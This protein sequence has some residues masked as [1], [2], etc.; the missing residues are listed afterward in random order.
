MAALGAEPRIRR[1]G[2][3]TVR[4]L[5]GL[6]GLNCRAIME[7]CQMMHQARYHQADSKP[8]TFRCTPSCFRHLFK[9][10]GRLEL[11]EPV[12]ILKQG[13]LAAV[14]DGFLHIG[15]RRDGIDVEMGEPQAEIA[16]VLLDLGS[17]TLCP[18]LVLSGK[19]QD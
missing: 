14:V 12:E 19:I 11:K 8:E 2:P 7:L 10:I 17:E 16:K 9:G 15:R 18:W 5:Q 4:A 13:E 1:D 6:C 3:V